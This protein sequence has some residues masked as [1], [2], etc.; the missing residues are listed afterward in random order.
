MRRWLIGLIAVFGWAFLI[1][2]PANAEPAL[3][4]QPLQYTETLKKGE[5]KKAFVDISNPSMQPVTVRLKVQAFKQV[6]DKGTLS[7]YDNQKITDGIQLD[8]Q[9]VEIPAKKALRLYFVVDGAKLPT[10]DVLAAIF[11]QTKPDSGAGAPAVRV[12]TLL[13]LTND[14]PGVRQAEITRFSVPWLQVGARMSGQVTIKNTAPV[15]STSGFFP[16]V[17]ISSWPFGKPVAI[18][19]PL[20]YTGITR[21]I[22]FEGPSNQLGVYKLTASFGTSHREVWTVIITG[23]WRWIIITITVAVLVAGWVFI[24]HRRRSVI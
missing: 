14:T 15:G 24:R 5:R 1:A 23:V 6:D 2:P 19:G 4:V 13:I 10:G 22:P 12:G 11:A 8:Y 7:F 21:T 16:T 20:I 3:G 9:E 18:H 17:T